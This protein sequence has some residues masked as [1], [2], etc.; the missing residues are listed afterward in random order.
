M[1]KKIIFLFL[2]VSFNLSLSFNLITAAST[3]ITSLPHTISTPGD[4]HLSTDLTTNGWGI[5]ISSNDVNLNCNN[6]NIVGLAATSS[7]TYGLY[8]A[9]ANNNVYINNCNVYN[10]TMSVSLY[11]VDNYNLENITSKNSQYGFSLDRTDDTILTNLKSI[12]NIVGFRLNLGGN[13][14]YTNIFSSD[15]TQGF[16]SNS[17]NNFFNNVSFKNNSLFDFDMSGKNNTFDFLNFT[18]SHH[19]STYPQNVI[20]YDGRLNKCKGSDYLDFPNINFSLDSDFIDLT[21]TGTCFYIAKDNITF[22]CNNH[23]MTV[24]KVVGFSMNKRENI[25][26]QNCVMNGFSSGVL[27]ST[28]LDPINT[29]FK[30]L[31]IYNFTTNGFAFKGLNSTIEDITI[32]NLDETSFFGTG[33]GFYI[34]GDNHL[35]KNINISN[36]KTTGFKIYKA[37]NNNIE[38]IKLI[39]NRVG[40]SFS[41]TISTNN[42]IDDF[43]IYNNSLSGIELGSHKNILKNGIIEENIRDGIYFNGGSN[44]DLSENITIINNAKNSVSYYD[45]NFHFTSLNNTIEF[46][47]FSSMTAS[48]RSKQ[49]LLSYD[50]KL[51][52]CYKFTFSEIIYELKSNVYETNNAQGCFIPSVSD[53]A[54]DCKNHKIYGNN[55]SSGYALYSGTNGIS[56]ISMKNCE[57]LNFGYGIRVSYTSNFKFENLLIHDNIGQGLDLH[58]NAASPPIVSNISSYNN[59]LVGKDLKLSGTNGIVS[60]SFFPNISKVQCIGTNYFNQSNPNVGN[61]Y[62]DLNCL[63]N[64]SFV[65]DDYNYTI[66]TNPSQV[67]ITATCIDY[68]P[69]IMTPKFIG[70]AALPEGSGNVNT[71][72]NNPNNFAFPFENIISTLLTITLIVFYLI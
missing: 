13:N 48:S 9:A 26:I 54:L 72:N 2:F 53:V 11:N 58:S 32:Y 20:S 35:I 12:N 7:G 71:H 23:K 59:N 19:K 49:N 64:T 36:S 41:D 18:D 25:K 30:N 65:Y 22:D 14:N 44:N 66:C 3:Q 62:G 68:A 47:N 63:A 37:K 42:S 16:T 31:E 28:S 8:S 38:N 33:S 67:N 43:I 70:I 45:L 51:S 24:N 21:S 50:A 56:N 52:S 5:T 34:S 4:Y 40:L 61:H 57:I 39:E 1:F 6:N 17:D 27:V 29:T 15:N 10:F 46:I 69:L 60:K 55:Y